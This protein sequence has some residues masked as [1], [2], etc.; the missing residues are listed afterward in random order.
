MTEKKELMSWRGW[1]IS[2]QEEP[3]FAEGPDL[4]FRQGRASDG[5]CCWRSLWTYISSRIQSL[6]I[7]SYTQRGQKTEASRPTAHTDYIVDIRR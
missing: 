6:S 5:M 4:E 2:I 1:N 7:S 3:S